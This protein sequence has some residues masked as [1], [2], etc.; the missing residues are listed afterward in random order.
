M[1]FVYTLFL[2]LLL[3]CS[4]AQVL[5]GTRLNFNAGWEFIKDV[6]K[7]PEISNLMDP[8]WKKGEWEK[9]D[10]PHSAHLEPV[11]K[12]K[13]QWQGTA[14]YRKYFSVPEAYRGKSISLKFEGAMNH[15][16]IFFNGKLV[17]EHWGGYL[18]FEV[19]ISSHLVYGKVNGVGVE[20]I[21][22]DNP[23]IPP[24]KPI[25]DLD[26][27]F[28]GGLYRSVFLLV[29]NPLHFTDAVEAHQE[30]GGGIQVHS[31]SVSREKG[32][33]IIKSE[34][35]NGLKREDF[36]QI[37][38]SLFDAKGIKVYAFSSIGKP[39]G[40]GQ[41][42][43]F[44]DS[45][46]LVHPHLW[47]PSDPYLYTLKVELRNKNGL[48]EVETIR[49]GFKKLE[50][51]SNQF[52]LNGE[53][54]VLRGTNRHQEYPYIGYALSDN[55]QYRDAYKIKAAGFNTVR[56]SHYPPSPAFLDACDAL[57]ILVMDAIP[58]WQFFGD[59]VFQKNSLQDIRDMLHRDRNHISICLWEAS[60]N[61]TNMSKAY[62]DSANSLVHKELPYP[63]V[64]TTGWMDYAYD[65][66]NP[67]R[68]HQKAPDFWKNWKA[69]K[70]LL[71][72]EYGD[73]EYYAGN[74][75]FNQKNYSDLKKEERNSRQVRGDGDKRLFQQ[76]LNFQEAHNDNLY[77]PGFGDLN[78]VM[79]DY[80]RGYA[81]DLETSGIMDIFRVP[82]FSFYF[83]QS[84]YGP[85][86]DSLGF[87][88]P[89]IQIAKTDLRKRDKQV[90]LYSN[91]DFVELFIGN[92]SLGKQR[93]D[94][95]RISKNLIH[96]PFTFML[97][98]NPEQD[99]KAIGYLG[100]HP[101]V[102]TRLFLAG[103]PDKLDL[104]MDTSGKEL[105][106]GKNDIVFLYCRV[107]DPNGHLVPDSQNEITLSLEGP[108]E[109]IGPGTIKA[110]NGIASFLV[111]GG[112]QKGKIHV[113]AV[114]NSL[115][116]GKLDAE[117]F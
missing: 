114:S 4:Q 39:M 83:Y 104:E 40:P 64:Y 75:G 46:S 107:L 60:L 110:E 63:G 96:A 106:S 73:W 49:T 28:Y 19:D 30:A 85:R 66:F 44:K 86:P 53:K 15:A 70:P 6:E 57:G 61:E 24:G 50:F 32:V 2:S 74:A 109:I 36:S 47:N 31:E 84:Q 112:K 23:Q 88:K 27:N 42:L 16:R 76:A 51:I 69:D 59:P 87:G 113:K 8:H 41:S 95:D 111:K 52:Y 81:D 29:Q 33:L 34:V 54:W 3:G 26:F 65:V 82:K 80:K 55:A 91:C 22:T 37:T 105:E 100:S 98:S 20:L 11:N 35:V 25:K 45:L 56:C 94:T 72:A 115:K 78:W 102:E 99:W 1:K 93:P 62:M 17:K 12:I 89:M 48:V 71:M 14:Y 90:G 101:V 67:A 108:G 10:L 7:A 38:Y 117:V 21:N 77:G 18:P 5:P 97:D 68:Q 79:F 9:V 116:S 92:K 43:E 13:E 58:G 103:K